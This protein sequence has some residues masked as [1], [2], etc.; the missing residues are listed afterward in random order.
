MIKVSV[1]Y[2]SGDEATFD[3]DYYVDKHIPMVADLL[4]DKLREVT[5]DRGLG[6]REPG[7]PPPYL[8][9]AHLHFDSVEDFQAAMGP[10]AEEIAA[11]VSN[12]TNTTATL[13]VSEVAK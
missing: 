8:A 6:G 9:M 3:H 10:H 5:V 1:L 2:P 13:Q 4:G 11:D 12:Y 7:A